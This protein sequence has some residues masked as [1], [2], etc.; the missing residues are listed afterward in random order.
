MFKKIIAIDVDGTLLNDQHEV[1]PFTLDILHKVRDQ[2]CGIILASGRGPQNG[3]P[4][5]EEMGLEGWMITHNGA[6]TVDSQTKEVINRFPI[7]LDQIWP[8]VEYA[9]KHNIH[10]DICTDFDQYVEN[11]PDHVSGMYRQFGIKPIRI[12]RFEGWEN[13]I[14]K[15]TLFGSE[16]QL[17][18][19]FEEI[20]PRFS[21]LN[22]IRSSIE[23]IDI[24][25]RQASKGNALREA[26]ETYGISKGDVIAFGNYF[27][28]LDMIEYAGTG[29][30]M[31][32]SP[33]E[34]K[35]AADQIAPSNNEDGVART[36][37]RLLN[38]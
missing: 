14:V 33:E 34:V 28:D 13:S 25:H 16:D 18:R 37:V 6:L 9:R 4:V 7:T 19:A 38:L 22:V 20:A 30:A 31:D 11:L 2:G 35:R 29:I 5:M 12:E 3:L 17:D 24:F 8:I 26:C 23:F 32:N 27:N 1:S 21:G 36:L 10:F 15:F